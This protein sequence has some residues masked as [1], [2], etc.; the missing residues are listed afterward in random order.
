[1]ST[2]RRRQLSRIGEDMSKGGLMDE[3]ILDMMINAVAGFIGVYSDDL[4]DNVIR[5]FVIDDIAEDHVDFHVRLKGSREPEPVKRLR[6]VLW[7]L[8]ESEDRL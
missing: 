4:G 2:P 7:T 6:L 5:T 3:E 8:P 1:M